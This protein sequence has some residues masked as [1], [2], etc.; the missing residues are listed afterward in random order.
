MGYRDDRDNREADIIIAVGLGESFED[1]RWMDEPGSE[2]DNAL[3]H[4]MDVV[5][6]R[7]AEKLGLRPG[8]VTPDMV[9]ANVG[10]LADEDLDLRMY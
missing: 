6:G 3:E 7:L 9:R 2:V 5:Y 4:N 1:R 10:L 8:E